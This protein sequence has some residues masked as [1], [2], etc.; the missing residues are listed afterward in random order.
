MNTLQFPAGFTIKDEIDVQPPVNPMIIIDHNEQESPQATQHIVVHDT[1]SPLRERVIDGYKIA[2]TWAERTE[3][4]EYGKKMLA[5]LSKSGVSGSRVKGINNHQDAAKLL[6]GVKDWHIVDVG[7]VANIIVVQGLLP[8]EYRGRAFAA[9]AT[10]RDIFNIFGNTGTRTIEHNRGHQNDDEFYQCTHI[11]FPTD[12]ITAQLK[13]HD[14]G[15]QFEFMQQWFAGPDKRFLTGTD[16]GSQ[17]NRCGV[18]IP[19]K[20]T[21]YENRQYRKNYQGHSRAPQR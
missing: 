11:E 21:R 4:A 8:E 2:V 12:I 20:D 14:N 1:P 5:R 6:S 9:Y 18:K 7:N 3:D 15:L 17:V 16:V 13:T 19:P 10:V